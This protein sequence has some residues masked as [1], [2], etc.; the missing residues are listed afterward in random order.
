MR[1]TFKVK[2]KDTSANV[3]G[4]IVASSSTYRPTVTFTPA[5][6]FEP[7]TNY[8]VVAFSHCFQLI[9]QPD[10]GLHSDYEWSFKT[11][12][13]RTHIKIAFAKLHNPFINKITLTND[14]NIF[15]AFIESVCATLMIDQKNIIATQLRGT[16]VII[17]NSADLS[18]LKERD[19]IDIIAE[20]LPA[21]ITTPQVP[22]EEHKALLKQVEQQ[23]E[24]LKKQ[25]ELLEV[26][27]NRIA[28]LE[29]YQPEKKDQSDT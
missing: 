18:E 12:G 16:E 25:A 27:Q 22:S 10:M 24:Q 5:A 13:K 19:V 3:T 23:Q 26:M 1:L 9:E 17:E 6:H 28:E 11:K 20:E 14:E 21:A 2:N 7:S 8:S 4:E 29:K 15:K